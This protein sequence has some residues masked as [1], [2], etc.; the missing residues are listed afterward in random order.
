MTNKF[1]ISDDD[2]IQIQCHLDRIK[3]IADAVR[4][5][6]MH[7]DM[8]ANQGFAPNALGNLMHTID[9]EIS[10]AGKVLDRVE[11]LDEVPGG[12]S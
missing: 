3:A 1:I 2:S 7:E 8:S 4:M 10:G 11:K 12:A 5:L 6:D 9:S